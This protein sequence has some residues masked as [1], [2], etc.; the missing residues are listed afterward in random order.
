M[1]FIRC[2]WCPW[3]AIHNGTI[4]FTNA[5]KVRLANHITEHLVGNDFPV[6]LEPAI[7]IPELPAADPGDQDD[8]SESSDEEGELPDL[9]DV[10]LNEPG[11]QPAM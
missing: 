10:P 4:N 11:G 7:D 9:E 6:D 5:Q 2:P 3:L 8:A 1:P